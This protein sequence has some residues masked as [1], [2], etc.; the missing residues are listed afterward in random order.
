MGENIDLLKQHVDKI[1]S[2]TSNSKSTFETLN[3]LLKTTNT[4]IKTMN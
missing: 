3:N 1:D 2:F 4:E